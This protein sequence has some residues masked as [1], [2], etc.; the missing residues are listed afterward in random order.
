MDT[1]KRG[2]HAEARETEERRGNKNHRDRTRKEQEE[3]EE[4]ERERGKADMRERGRSIPA[5]VS[6]LTLGVVFLDLDCV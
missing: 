2:H 4:R 3:A 5:L 6:S 1:S